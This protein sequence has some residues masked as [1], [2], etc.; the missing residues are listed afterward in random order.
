VI[1]TSC[2]SSNKERRK[3]T[4]HLPAYRGTL[5][6]KYTTTSPASPIHHISVSSPQ[7]ILN[8]EPD[9]STRRSCAAVWRQG[10][11]GMRGARSTGA[12]IGRGSPTTCFAQLS[13]HRLACAQQARLLRR[14]SQAAISAVLLVGVQ[15]N[16]GG[17]FRAAG[18]EVASQPPAGMTCTAEVK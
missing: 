11:M 8:T 16:R 15:G 1:T 12:A 5:S 3:Q 9:G 14:A 6:H 2:N 4:R 17:T 13:L 10:I 7:Y 18:L